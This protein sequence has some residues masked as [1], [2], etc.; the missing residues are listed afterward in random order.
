MPF[1]V[2]VTLTY[3]FDDRDLSGFAKLTELMQQLQALGVS[4]QVEVKGVDPPAAPVVAKQPARTNGKDRD[5]QNKARTKPAPVAEAYPG[6]DDLAGDA[7]DAAGEDELIPGETVGKSPAEAREQGL[8]MVR[9]IYN[10]GYKREVKLLQQDFA[11]AKFA[12]VPADKGHEFL[13]RVIEL[14]EKTGISV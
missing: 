2:Q 4:P 14:A 13:K 8:V 9:A 10:A 12:D 11:V 3:G 6:V 1:T 5:H 7:L